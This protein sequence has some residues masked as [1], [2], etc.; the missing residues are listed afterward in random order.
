MTKMQLSTCVNSITS[1]LKY[2]IEGTHL[3]KMYAADTR[4]LL[5]Y[6]KLAYRNCLQHGCKIDNPFNYE[7]SLHAVNVSGN[8]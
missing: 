8:Q 7:V 6:S 2:S 3:L 5:Q 4:V 1:A